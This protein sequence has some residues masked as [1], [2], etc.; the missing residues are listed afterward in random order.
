VSRALTQRRIWLAAFVALVLPF[1]AVQAWDT[2][3]TAEGI[4]N[5]R[6]CIY[7]KKKDTQVTIEKAGSPN[8][9]YTVMAQVSVGLNFKKKK[10][11]NDEEC[12]NVEDPY[13]IDGDK[14]N[15]TDLAYQQAREEHAERVPC[16]TW[17]YKMNATGHYRG[18][19]KSSDSWLN[20]RLDLHDPDGSATDPCDQNAGGMVVDTVYEFYVITQEYKLN[21]TVLFEPGDVVTNK[22]NGGLA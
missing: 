11:K 22:R 2:A 6:I 18:P 3:S 12:P 8:D 17:L 5:R 15:V 20:I 4:T 16:E 14:N 1:G 21:G 13:H 19:I 10:R 7:V 9:S